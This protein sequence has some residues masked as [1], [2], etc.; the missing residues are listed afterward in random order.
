MRRLAPLVAS[1]PVSIA[2]HLV[3]I[4]LRKIVSK[5]QNQ[6]SRFYLATAGIQAFGQNI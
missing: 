1:S 5:K 2:K 4:K 3:K 6:P